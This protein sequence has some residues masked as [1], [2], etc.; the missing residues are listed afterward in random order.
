MH[1][2]FYGCFLTIKRLLK[3]HP[4]HPGGFDTVPLPKSS[5]IDEIGNNKRDV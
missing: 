2:V 4:G 5:D 3:C 1:G